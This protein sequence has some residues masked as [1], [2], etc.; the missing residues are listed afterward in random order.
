MVDVCSKLA[1][2]A[3]VYVNYQF[4]G[5]TDANGIIENALEYKGSMV[6]IVDRINDYGFT[7]MLKPT[8]SDI[9]N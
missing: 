5:K 7:D 9:F 3:S 6:H 2:N 4:Y 8:Y 1:I